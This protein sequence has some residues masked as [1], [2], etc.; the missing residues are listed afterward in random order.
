[1]ADRQNPNH[2][3]AISEAEITAAAL[4]AGVEVY[5]PA[6]EHARADLVFGLGGR[7]FKIQC[8]T[9]HWRGGVLIVNLT[10]N[11]RSAAGYVRRFYA[12]DEIDAVAAHDPDT[13]QN[14]LLPIELVAEMRAITLR[15]TPPL[16]GQRARL[17]YAADYEF[18][19]AVA[20]LGERLSGTQKVVGSS[21]I[22]SISA[23]EDVP[24][25]TG[26]TTVGAHEFRNRFG[27]YLERAAAG[28]T[29]DVSRHGNAHVRLG[30]IAPPLIAGEAGQDAEAA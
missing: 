24:A 12:A 25:P 22:S 2:R 15:V 16:N 11:S 7:L 28:E 20:Q 26:Q 18:Q 21:P 4:R 1:V 8:K 30:P 29:I 6:S 3:G 17:H 9:A 14:F 19:G 5:R 10:R 13:N 23:A 27:W